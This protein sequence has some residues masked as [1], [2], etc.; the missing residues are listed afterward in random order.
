[1]N[2]AE[3]ILARHGEWAQRYADRIANQPRFGGL[4]T[5]QR[6]DLYE[7]VRLA[8]LDGA[9]AEQQVG[10]PTDEVLWPRNEDA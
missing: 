3:K 6:A 7:A 5:N 10:W 9:L 2:D 8:V 4:T 1:M